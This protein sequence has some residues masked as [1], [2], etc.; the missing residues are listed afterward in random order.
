MTMLERSFCEV[1]S[2]DS[3]ASTGHAFVAFPPGLGLE[4]VRAWGPRAFSRGIIGRAELKAERAESMP[5]PGRVLL[6]G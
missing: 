3:G 2:Q 1:R 6:G 5:P 4:I